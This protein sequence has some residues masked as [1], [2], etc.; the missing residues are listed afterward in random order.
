MQDPWF[1]IFER[2]KMTAKQEYGS[3]KKF[4]DVL[5]DPVKL[6]I[7]DADEL[8]RKNILAIFCSMSLSEN[9]KAEI[10]NLCDEILT[11]FPESSEFKELFIRINSIYAT[12]AMTFLRC[13]GPDDFMLTGSSVCVFGSLFSHSC[14]QN[15]DRVALDNKMVYYVN[16]PIKAGEQIFIDY[17]P[18]YALT[19]LHERRHILSSYGFI[20]DCDACK[21]NFP[22]L[23]DLR[24]I[25]R[26]NQI[27]SFNTSDIDQLIETFKESCKLINELQ[28]EHPCYDTAFVIRRNYYEMNR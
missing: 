7:F 21:N 2:I 14:N 5:M 3:F 17:G 12:N 23:N 28:H 11:M 6:T 20:C 22:L 18:V 4:Y 19:P 9:R 1:E 16:R 27:T 25:P 24:K 15:I 26:I 10:S 13:T 8:S